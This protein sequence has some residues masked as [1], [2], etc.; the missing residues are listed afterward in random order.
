MWK[1]QVDSFQPQCGYQ[2]VQAHLPWKGQVGVWSSQ[3]S[4]VLAPTGLL[5]II[6]P[7]TLWHFTPWHFA[8]LP[9]R[10]SLPI[11]SP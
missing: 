11:A 3:S 7:E 5:V 4:G 8:H 1:G 10:A 9:F 2:P 6:L